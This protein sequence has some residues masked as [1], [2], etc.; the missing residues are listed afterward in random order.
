MANVEDLTQVASIAVMQAVGSYSPDHGTAIRTWIWRRVAGALI[1]YLRESD[2]LTRP[3]RRES[4]NGFQAVTQ[5]EDEGEDNR[6]GM[7]QS[8]VRSHYADPEELCLAGEIRELIDRYGATSARDRR[9]MRSY[10]LDEEKMR[11]IAVREGMV[12]SRVSQIVTIELSRLR[13]FATR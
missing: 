13:A 3:Q 6:T 10:F 1:D 2:P 4:G 7:R 8:W 12:E 5:F 11:E 9:I